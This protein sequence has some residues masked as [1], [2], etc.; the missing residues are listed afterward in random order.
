MRGPGASGAVLTRC[1]VLFNMACG[2]AGYM[3]N[4]GSRHYTRNQTPFAIYPLTLFKDAVYS[5]AISPF[6]VTFQV[7]RAIDRRRRDD[8]TETLQRSGSGAGGSLQR[9][10]GRPGQL[11]A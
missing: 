5:A 2:R 1:R 7:V 4:E 9:T 3:R 8:R 10:G 11:L 6:P